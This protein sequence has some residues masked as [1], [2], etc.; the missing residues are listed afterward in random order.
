D[1]TRN[2]LDQAAMAAAVSDTIQ[3][4]SL[5]NISVAGSGRNPAASAVDPANI[6]VAKNMADA[7][8]SRAL[9]LGE[10][11]TQQTLR[12]LREVIRRMSLTPGMRQV[13]LIS[14]GFLITS[15]YRQD[16]Q[17]MMDRAVHAN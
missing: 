17:E 1:L 10:S 3:C 12:V 14:P 16:E 2:H 13:V 11:E 5:T 15:T 6:Q 9:A 8:S 7:A 4:A